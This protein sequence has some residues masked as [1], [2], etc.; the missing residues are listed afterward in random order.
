M[1]KREYLQGMHQIYRKIYLLHGD[2]DRYT[3]DE[4][5]AVAELFLQE[6]PNARQ[7]I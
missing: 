4:G 2:K 7:H 3:Y 5:K 6:F 1:R